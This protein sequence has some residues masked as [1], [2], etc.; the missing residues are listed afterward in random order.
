MATK[1]GL[2][3]RG[4]TSSVFYLITQ[5]ASPGPRLQAPGTERRPPPE[6]PNAA[7]WANSKRHF[8]LKSWVVC[9]DSTRVPQICYYHSPCHRR[10]AA[11]RPG[12]RTETSRPPD[13]SDVCL[14]RC[15]EGDVPEG[16]V[17][18]MHTGLPALPAALPVGQIH[19]GSRRAEGHTDSHAGCL[20]P[21][22]P[23]VCLR[24]RER[25]QSRMRG[26]EPTHPAKQTSLLWTIRGD[27]QG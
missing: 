27:R 19:A 2:S 26:L 18:L 9:S 13:N 10:L 25:R 4:S 17:G 20:E 23:N 14:Q 5:K 22:C 15:S 1:P 7:R 16:L 3:D 11:G 8:S 12:S 24:R 21:S 6:R